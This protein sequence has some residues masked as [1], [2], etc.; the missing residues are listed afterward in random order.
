MKKTLQ[1]NRYA[2]VNITQSINISLEEWKKMVINRLPNRFSSNY[3][4]DVL[5]LKLRNLYGSCVPCVKNHY[6]R[7]PKDV[8]SIVP[9]TIVITKV[10]S[11]YIVRIRSASIANAL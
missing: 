2:E 8:I 4:G 7:K 5:L 3:Y 11:I 1:K 9:A 6:L 10:M